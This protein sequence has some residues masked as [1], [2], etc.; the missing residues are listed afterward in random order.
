MVTVLV[1]VLPAGVDEKVMLAGVALMNLDLFA[2]TD[3]PQDRQENR[4]ATNSAFAPARSLLTD[5]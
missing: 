1:A 2:A 5:I 3:A 4:S